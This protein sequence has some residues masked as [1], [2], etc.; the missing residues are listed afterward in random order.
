VALPKE[1][2][3]L[4]TPED[5]VATS[6]PLTENLVPGETPKAE[7]PASFSTTLE[8]AQSTGSKSESSSSGDGSSSDKPVEEDLAR[9]REA[10]F[11]EKS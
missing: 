4:A 7:D 1:P 2:D 3:E 6:T 8:S 5:E 9:V 10:L 11:A